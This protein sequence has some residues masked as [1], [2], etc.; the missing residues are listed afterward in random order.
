MLTYYNY[1]TSRIMKRDVI[2]TLYTPDATAALSHYRDHLRDTRLRLQEKKK[3]ALFT[4]ES[5]GIV[6]LDDRGVETGEASSGTE[7]DIQKKSIESIPKSE[8][9][10]TMVDIAKRY[11]ALI[12]EMEEVKSEIRRLEN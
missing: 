1:N 6:G 9:A 4:L 10:R 2:S 5:Y 11:G 3:T 12:M 8:N 7:S